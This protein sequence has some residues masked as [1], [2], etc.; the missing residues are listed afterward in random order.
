MKKIFLFISIFI[1][2]GINAQKSQFK[3][4]EIKDPLLTASTYSALKFRSV[5][6]ALVSGRI[7]DIAVNPNKKSQWIIAVA[8][9]GVWKTDN[10]GITFNPIFDSQTSFSI[11]C[12]TMDP[13]N[14][15]VIW[16]GTGENNNQRS[17]AYGDGVYKSE[18]GG[19][20]WNNMG[21][22]KSEH[23]GK[24]VV[25]PTNSDVV[26]VAA[27]GPL[28]SAGGERGIYKTTDGGKN[29]KQILQVS[30]NTGFNEVHIDPNHPNI[31]YATAHQ[32]RRHEWT[33]I[34]GGPE[35][36]IY[37]SNDGGANW[38]KLTNGLPKSDM[39]RI[40][41]AIS[42]VNTDLIYAII[43]GS[44][45][46]KGFYRSLDRGA[47]WEKKSNWATM[48]NYY[49]EIIADPKN[50][51]KV[52]SLDSWAQVSVDGGNTFKGIGEKNK[53][54]DN[55][56]LYVD[57]ENTDHMI[58]GCDGGLYETW[59]GAKYWDFKSNLPITQFYRV[60]V[61]NSAPFYYIYGGTQDNNSMGGPSR[62][63]SASGILNSDW[64]IT[65]GGDGFETAIDPKDPNIVYSQWQYGGL[66]RYDRKSGE[67][68]DI[69]PQEK[70]GEA[71]YRWNWDA[72]L[73][74]SQFD[75]TRLYF[76]ANKIFRSDD[77]GNTWQAISNDL[78]RGIDRNKLAVMG[79][80]W[81]MDAIAKNASTS[82]YGNVTA[83]A[84]S[85]KNENV[86]YAGTDD[87][88]IQI[89]NNNGKSWTKMEKFA[90]VPDRTFVQNIICSQ[91]DENTAYVVFN[92]HRSGDFKP[93]ILKTSDKGITWTSISSDLPERGSVYCVAEDHVNKNLLF[94]G[95]EFGVYFTIN[96]GAKW[97]A[98]N[99]GLPT[100]CVRDMA[101]QKRENDLVLATFGRGFYVLDDYSVLQKIKKEDLEQ[102][103]KLFPIKG[104]LVYIESTPLGHKGKSNQGESFYTAD[105]PPVGANITYWIK[106]DIKT[107][108]E[109]RKESE[110]EKI[111]NNQPIYYPSADSI[112][113][114]DLEDAAYLM[115]VI[116]DENANVI[117][118]IKQ[119]AKKGMY[120]IN[121]N[122]RLDVTSPVSLNRL[123]S[124][125]PYDES[126]QGPL[127]LPGKYFVHLVKVENGTVEKITDNTPFELL[128][129]NNSTLSVNTKELNDFNKDLSEFR[130][131][132]LATSEYCN[133]VNQRVK[134]IKAGVLQMNSISEDLI[135]DVKSMELLLQN[136][137]LALNGDKSLAKREFE[138][139]SG[140]VG[141]LEGIV[142]NLWSTSAQ[143]TGTYIKNLE[144]CKKIFS[145]IYANLKLLKQKIELL[146]S[147]MEIRK[148]P[149]TPGRFPEYNEK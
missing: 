86:I 147:K 140:L 59:D 81:S 82:I 96:G 84:E 44:H 121:W 22:K 148:A 83:L 89:T 70:E 58:M 28:W 105:N 78:S 31:I 95:T 15:N 53:H 38:T 122:G 104:A 27:Y 10:A 32:R 63:T 115:L 12:V 135:S 120:R 29:W 75:N 80:V 99:N 62:T 64:F 3:K 65:V 51:D 13:N 90:G 26:Y 139:L 25:D 113:M 110:K 101:I 109:K 60:S 33:Y 66:V 5:G 9:G 116:S 131:V 98:L 39:G 14:S 103:A 68:I 1:S 16:V 79:K 37:K 92:N 137:D 143:Q 77:Y 45:D 17:V 141:K 111:K 69:K 88:L 42:P 146:E 6:P 76:A 30:E 67:A 134:Y 48:G 20:T 61:D 21:L 138:T 114:E 40:G 94:V 24:I 85:P 34:S 108:K 127:A 87:G 52:F 8:S 107:I 46:E 50:A 129:L 11:G 145:I 126:D 142:G 35:S 112:R 144:Q 93:Y 119:S 56:A 72:P 41:L 100:I 102:K 73:I 49:Q 128:T 124:D 130:R 23:I 118:K 55:H 133:S 43:E 19:K 125:N 4:E 71:A 36:A 132:V 149:Y 91:H 97:V 54:V 136:I 123:S 106:D 18:D 117:R 47:S 74:I 2:F 57:P 7:I